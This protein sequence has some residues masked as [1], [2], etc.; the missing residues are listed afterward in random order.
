[1]GVDASTST[2]RETPRETP[3]RVLFL[4]ESPPH[5]HPRR[6]DVAALLNTMAHILQQIALLV[7][8]Y[9]LTR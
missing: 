4:S 3:R 6:V 7:A 9:N 5:A 8:T 2:P 1:V